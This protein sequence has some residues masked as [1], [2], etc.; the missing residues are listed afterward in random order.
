[1]ILKAMATTMMLLSA[2]AWLNA[3]DASR[4]KQFV[5]TPLTKPLHEEARY[6]ALQ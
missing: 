5:A 4:E 2:A 6:R 3:D 1:M